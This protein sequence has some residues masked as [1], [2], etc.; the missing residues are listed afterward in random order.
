M[1]PGFLNVMFY[2]SCAMVS[3][4]YLFLEVFGEPSGCTFGCGLL[5]SWACGISPSVS[6]GSCFIIVLSGG[7]CL[8]EITSS[9]WQFC[10]CNSPK[11]SRVELEREQQEDK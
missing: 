10:K 6:P 2:C 4:I 1:L 9:L 3:S 8:F 11:S 5:G 7:G